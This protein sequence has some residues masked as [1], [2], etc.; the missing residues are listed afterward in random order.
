MPPPSPPP[1]EQPC[2]HRPSLAIPSPTPLQNHP[3]YYRLSRSRPTLAP[4]SLPPT[5]FFGAPSFPAFFPHQGKWCG[6]EVE[7]GEP[8]SLERKVKAWVSLSL[9][10]TQGHLLPPP[11]V[12][13][14]KLQVGRGS[15][16]QGFNLFP[17]QDRVYFSISRQSRGTHSRHLLCVSDRSSS[18]SSGP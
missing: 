5:L 10:F 1:N 17:L 11:P 16:S 15:P 9:P 8:P 12:C 2:H 14:V 18:S 6:G 3:D 4:P 7:R 13:K